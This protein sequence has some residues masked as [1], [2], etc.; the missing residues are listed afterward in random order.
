M[1]NTLPG[2]LSRLLISQ[3]ACPHC[4]VVSSK[5]GAALTGRSVSLPVGLLTSERTGL[6]PL[7]PLN[8]SQSQDKMHV[9]QLKI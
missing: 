1:G 2:E 6:A 7:N 9:L 8:V 3:D 5:H 4:R